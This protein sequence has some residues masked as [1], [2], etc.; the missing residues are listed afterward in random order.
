MIFGVGALMLVTTM[1]S[2][3]DAGARAEGARHREKSLHFV[4]RYGIAMAINE[5][6][7]GRVDPTFGD[8]TGNG[9]GCILVGDDGQPGWPVYTS[10]TASQRRLLGR[11]KTMVQPAPDGVRKVLSVVAVDGAF[12]A[13][14]T[15]AQQR[16]QAGR[17][18]VAAAEVEI[19]R[20]PVFFDRNALSIRGPA[21]AGGRNGVYIKGGG[22]ANQVKI[23]GNDV[24]AVNIS[25]PDLHALFVDPTTIDSWG[26]LQGLDP[27]TGSAALTRPA[28]VTNDEAGLL[29]QETLNQVAEGIND[30]VAGILSSGTRITDLGAT[31]PEGEYFVDSLATI[32]GTLSGSG[33]LVITQGVELNGNLN[34][35]GE[36]IVANN[37]NAQV[38]VN[39]AAELNVNGILAIQGIGDA[40]E[41]GV[42]VKGG[43]KVNVGTATTP[44]ALTILG[45]HRTTTPLKFSS[46]S[47]GA[48][49][50]GVM[51]ILG[52][53]LTLDFDT[54]AKIDV[55]GSLACVTPTDAEVGLD[56]GFR[57]GAHMTLDYVSGNFDS[58][59]KQLG[60]FFDPG[61]NVLPLSVLGY[62]EDPA[63][64]LDLLELHADADPTQEYGS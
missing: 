27:A 63:N 8:P 44:G 24:P 23:Y 12:P 25:D 39:N 43:G 35:T 28:T 59:V 57:S 36:V 32:N 14:W 41:M 4:A 37:S 2:L 33:T 19:S 60:Q 22:K 11:F 62:L 42:W 10:G 49:V 34:W 58:A 15:E 61:N 13:S 31:L 16:L 40:T 54:G 26:E 53:A 48:F 55:K 64:R 46:G 6:N 45:D 5:I 50:Q 21:G 47:K 38:R 30:R 18:T 51:S 3:M 7:R 9:V 1:L 29:N 17:L 20:A 56:V 52:N